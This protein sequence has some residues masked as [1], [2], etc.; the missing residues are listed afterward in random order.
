VVQLDMR[1][2]RMAVALLLWV[3]ITFAIEWWPFHFALDPSRVRT[4][5]MLWSRSPLRLPAGLA[6]VLP[7]TLL[8]ATVGKLARS[9]FNARFL[10]LQTVV[11][12]GCAALAFIAAESGRLL[13]DGG[14]PT[15]LSVLLKVTALLV[16][17]WVGSHRAAPMLRPDAAH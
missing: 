15:L 3:A 14:R 4:Q 8:A 7:G 11:L 16:G 10:R 13:L 9:Q 5:A 12:V 17:L 6:A 2:V 1:I